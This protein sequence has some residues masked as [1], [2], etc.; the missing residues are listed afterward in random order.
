MA[1]PATYADKTLFSEL[2]KEYH[3]LKER[4]DALVLEMGDLED[5]VA[6]LEARREAL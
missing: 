1:D 2:S 4:S 3:T 5:A 6:A